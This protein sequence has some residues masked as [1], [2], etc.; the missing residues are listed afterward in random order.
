[1]CNDVSIG[2]I[3]ELIADF[4][5]VVHAAEQTKPSNSIFILTRQHFQIFVLPA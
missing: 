4:Y 1:M 5:S 2:G 3:A